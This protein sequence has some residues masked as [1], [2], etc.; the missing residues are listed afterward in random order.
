M[1][2]AVEAEVDAAPAVHNHGVQADFGEAAYN[3]ALEAWLSAAPAPGAPSREAC[4]AF[5]TR[6]LAP[7]APAA[8]QPLLSLQLATRHHSPRLEAARHLA[9]QSI[10]P[11][12]ARAHCCAAFLDGELIV[13]AAD[14]VKALRYAAPSPPTASLFQRAATDHVYRHASSSSSPPRTLLLYGPPGNPCF[15]R[16]HRAALQTLDDGGIAD[17][18]YIV[19]PVALPGCLKAADAGGSVSADACLWLGTE[20]RPVLSGYGVQLAIKN[21]EYVQVRLRPVPSMTPWPPAEWGGGVSM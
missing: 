9:A 1:R 12:V 7:A 20:Q 8:V 5:A 18:T 10:P 21:M 4:W 16:L 17:V 19:R 15:E 3:T 13:S 6:T 2:T 14:A 11:E